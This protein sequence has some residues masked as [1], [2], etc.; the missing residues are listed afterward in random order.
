MWSNLVHD[1][2]IGEASYASVP[3][4]VKIHRARGVPD[5]NTYALI[6]SI[7]EVRGVG[8]NPKLPAWLHRDYVAA[9]ADLQVLALAE[10]PAARCDELVESILSVLAFSKGRIT[11]GRLA[12]LTESERRAMLDCG[13][14]EGATPCR[15]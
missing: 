1:D 12:L 9:W 11:L 5:W 7:E 6:S 15:R 2:R 13:A 14:A 10:F 4:I 3:H 8:G